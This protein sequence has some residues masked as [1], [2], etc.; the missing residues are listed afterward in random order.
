VH[1]RAGAREGAQ[2]AEERGGDG[3]G[4][5]VNWGEGGVR[6]ERGRGGPE[7]RCVGDRVRGEEVAADAERRS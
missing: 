1:G 4:G 6:E 7:A 5:R 2:P 3:R